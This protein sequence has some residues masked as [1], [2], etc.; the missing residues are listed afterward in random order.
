MDISILKLLPRARKNVP[1]APYTT[2]K[3]GGSAKYFFIAQKTKDIADALE[4]ARSLKMPFFVLAG[5]S[6]VL[7]ADKGFFGLVIYIQ[8]TTYKIQGTKLYAE[9]GVDFPLIVQETGKKGLAGLE[10]AGGLP[11]SIVYCS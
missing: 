6:N 1:L 9:A 4:A 7:I 3:I 2:F 8:N 11:G 10:W 5:G